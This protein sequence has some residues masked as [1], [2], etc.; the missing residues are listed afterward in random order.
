MH[1]KITFFSLLCSMVLATATPL[2]AQTATPM[3]L[4]ECIQYGLDN[5]PN[6]KVARL[7][8]IDA[9]WRIKENKATGL[10][11]ASASV[12]Y[13][14]FIQRGGLPSS[15][16]SFGPSGPPPDLN[17]V[18]GLTSDQAGGVLQ[19]LGSLFQTDPNAK[20][21]FSPVHNLS[22]T[23]GVNQL[24]FNNSY[25][26]AIKAAR[27]YREYVDIQLNSARFGVTNAVRDAYLPALLLSENVKTLDKNIANLEKL[28]TETQA[29]NKAGFAEQLDVDRL[30]L[31]VLTLRSE[32]GNLVRQRE[33][34]VNALKM[35]MGMPIGNTL[36]PS[37]DI[38]KLMAADAASVDLVSAPNFMNRP[39]YLQILKGRELS[40]LQLDLYRK[41]FAPTVAGFLQY[42]PNVQGGFGTKGSDGFNK[43]FFIPSAVAG[44]NV[45]VT[46]W[47]SG[48][49]KARKERAMIAVQ[50]IE[51][52]KEMLENA[53]SLELDAA[54]KQYMN[55]QERVA[56]QQ[57]NLDLA[58]RIYDTI[59]KKYKAGIGSSFEITQAESGLYSAQ[60]AL[61]Q[62]QYD[63]LAAKM[64]IKKAGL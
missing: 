31:S 16:L 32:R 17:T 27:Y 50:T 25:L 22:G 53:L 30:E 46:L 13:T 24:I 52:Q 35:A 38:Q 37:D 41:P 2:L 61:M 4:D 64:A 42:Q 18:P 14:G 11:Q 10:P 45:S 1:H 54:R 28:L 39:E 60:Q 19:L 55:A 3:T 44:I 58:Q 51:A 49:N 15:A 21:F 59:Q 8:V 56:N 33:I 57:K 29:I 36:E 7:A 48:L 26:V 20:V 40:A 9:E 47:D 5:H 12:G 62:A 43:W 34:V 63:L 6:V 23:I